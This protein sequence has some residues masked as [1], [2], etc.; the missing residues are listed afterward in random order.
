[1]IDATEAAEEGYF[2]HATAQHGAVDEDEAKLSL[3]GSVRKTS[4]AAECVGGLALAKMTEC[5][6]LL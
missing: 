4:Q 3:S 6:F 1:M 5:I 2:S